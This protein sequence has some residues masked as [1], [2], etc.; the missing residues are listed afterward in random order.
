M[1]GEEFGA[2]TSLCRRFEGGLIVVR[3]E[4]LEWGTVGEKLKKEV[5]E[6]GGERLGGMEKREANDAKEEVAYMEKEGES[7]GEG[8][9]LR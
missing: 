1:G 5:L 9:G 4:R 7:Q 2:N 8:G 3:G 6:D